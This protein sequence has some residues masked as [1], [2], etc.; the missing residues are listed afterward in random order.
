MAYLITGSEIF[1]LKNPNK[2]NANTNPFPTVRALS[3]FD[4]YKN[5]KM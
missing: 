4:V 5:L 1:A 3:F 2:H